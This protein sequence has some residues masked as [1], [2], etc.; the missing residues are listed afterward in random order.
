MT[1]IS[2]HLNILDYAISL[3]LRRRLKSV[4]LL[5]VFAA[6]IFLLSS[7]QL[8]TTAL[9]DS[10]DTLLSGVP[11]ITVQQMSAGRQVGLLQEH[12]NIDNDIFGISRVR[13]R[14]WGYY[15]DEKNGA[16]YTVIGL[17]G[18]GVANRLQ[19]ALQWGRLPQESGEVVVAAPVMNNLGLGQ[20]RSF[21]LFRPDLSLKSLHVVGQFAEGTGLVTDDLMFMSLPDAGDLFA[22]PPGEITDLL[23]DVANPAEIDTIAAKI[24]D[25]LAGTRVI[26]KKQ[27]EKTYDVVFSWR[28][29]VGSI[30]LLTSL[31]AFIILAWDRASGLSSEERREMAILKVTG[32]QTGDIMLLR[33]WES[34]VIACVALLVGY[35]A[36]WYHV[37]FLDGVLLQPVLLGW[38][39]LEP[40]YA[41]F[42][43]F[44][45]ADVLVIAACSV[46][47]Y[48]MATIVPAWK[49]AMVRH[50]SVI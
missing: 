8:V 6:V 33:F 12:H 49:S 15:F 45:I 50:D 21:S 31:F 27:I 11:D 19:R 10:A 30:A 26:T 5:F 2:K 13:Q 40:S 41:L 22:T 34:A 14:I 36:A 46:V 43:P 17:N 39:V 1:A 3:L 7:F 32:W 37:A 29:G 23:I 42:P 24:A 28:S 20:R 25:K 38:S 48:M 47:P 18:D 44:R 4:L 35:S 9:V 16:N